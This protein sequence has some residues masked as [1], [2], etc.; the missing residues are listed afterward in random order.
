MTDGARTTARR[1]SLRE[2]IALVCVLAMAPLAPAAVA[3]VRVVERLWC[4]DG[5]LVV[6]GSAVYAPILRRA[7]D[8]YTAACPDSSIL[9]D[10]GESAE[11]L[12]RL[13]TSGEPLDGGPELLAVSDGPKGRGVQHLREKLFASK[14]FA[15]AVNPATGVTDLSAQQIDDIHAGRVTSW[16]QVGGND[17]PLSPVDRGDSTARRIL[18]HRILG[19]PEPTRSGCE[20]AAAC[21][22]P[23]SAEVLGAIAADP[24][25]F[26]YVEAGEITDDSGVRAVRIDGE[27]APKKVTDLGR[28]PFHQAGFAY[29]REDAPFLSLA[30]SFQNYLAN[31]PSR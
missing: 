10:T 15:L 29:V 18:E 23:S 26:G 4:A 2:T 28:Y 13:V 31:N 24:G 20:N 19:D 12:R 30:T 16:A 7:A 22:L 27:L 1:R 3:S 14:I 8:D 5:R 17:V 21:E 6:A 9:I 25:G 11:G